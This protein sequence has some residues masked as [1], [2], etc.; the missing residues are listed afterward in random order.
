MMKPQVQKL[1]SEQRETF[2]NESHKR[3]HLEKPRTMWW[4]GGQGRARGAEDAACGCKKIE[5][6]DR[7]GAY[8]EAGN[9]LQA[10]GDWVL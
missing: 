9:C 5:A 1:T 8:E 6:P 4:I 10:R 7:L 2:V 3:K